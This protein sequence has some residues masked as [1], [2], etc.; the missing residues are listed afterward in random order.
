[1]RRLLLGALVGLA[2]AGPSAWGFRTGK[3][4]T[5]TDLT[6]DQMAELNVFLERLWNVSNGRYSVDVVTANPNGARRGDIGDVIVYNNNGARKF[7]T[8]TDGGT[9]WQCS[10]NALTAP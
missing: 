4:P 3:P 2:L 10:A 8:N 5:L 1:M 6:P 9:A 7:C